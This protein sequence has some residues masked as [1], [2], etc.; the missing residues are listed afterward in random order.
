MARADRSCG[1][2]RSS[3]KGVRED[4][5]LTATRSTTGRSFFDTNVLVYTDDHDAPEKQQ[6]ALELLARARRDGTGVVSTQVLQA[7]PGLDK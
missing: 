5:S 2:C 6:R 3:P 7:R 4:G 1:G